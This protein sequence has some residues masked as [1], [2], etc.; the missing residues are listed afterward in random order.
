VTAAAPAGSIEIGVIGA[1]WWAAQQYIPLL[2][3]HANV[4]AVAVTRPDR[5]GLD[6]LVGRFGLLHTFTDAHEML[7]ER[8]LA[9]VIVS[10][11]HVMHAAHAMMCIGRGLPTLIEKPMTASSADARALVAAAQTRNCPIMVA[12]GW[13]YRPIAAKARKLVDAG[14]VGM[15]RHGVCHIASATG[16]LMSGT[17]HPQAASHL[18]QPAA[19]T[20]SD[21]LRAGG[22]G[23][24]QLTHALGLLFLLVDLAPTRVFARMGLG[25]TGADLFDAAVLELDNGA[26]ISLSGA[27]GLSRAHRKQLD[28]RLFGSDGVMFLDVERPRLDVSRADGE[29]LSQSLNAGDEDYSVAEVIERFVDLCRGCSVANPATGLIGLRAVEVLDAMHRSASSN[30]FE[31]V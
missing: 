18:F 6:A 13:N 31:P 17:G 7:A 11:P 15:L 5:D 2:L 25:P 14:W 24:G 28:I 9:G 10:S 30:Q 21:P 4:S 29:V 27:A 1:G 26:T 22:F 20:W 12:Y 3:R 8:P 23:W 16:S 19:S